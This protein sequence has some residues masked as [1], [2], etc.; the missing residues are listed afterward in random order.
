MGQKDREEGQMEFF[1]HF[2][3]MIFPLF[4][5]FMGVLGMFMGTWR[6]RQAMNLI[7]SY[8]DQG[9]EPPPELIRIASGASDGEGGARMS[10]QQSSGWSFVVFAAIA[11]GF[12][13]AYYSVRNEQFAFAFLM[14]TVIMGVMALGALIMLFFPNRDGACMAL[15]MMS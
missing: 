11:A 13:T 3:W 10:P 7:K 9:K 15:T 4:G 6:S 2:W 12:G 5:M 8:V 14:V 1:R